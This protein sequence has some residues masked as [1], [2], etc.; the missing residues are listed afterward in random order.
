MAIIKID[1]P[2]M[3]SQIKQRGQT[4]YTGNKIS[5]IR[6]KSFPLQSSSG[7]RKLISSYLFNS[8]KRWL[9]L[10]DAN[11]ESWNNFSYSFPYFP[12]SQ[13]DQALMG[14][15]IFIKRN[16]HQQILNTSSLQFIDSP[17]PVS[18]DP[19]PPEVSIFIST[20]NL[21][22]SLIF[23]LSNSYFDCLISLSPPISPGISY[24]KFKSRIMIKPSNFTQTIDITQI[25]ISKFGRLPVPG[26]TIIFSIIEMGK[27][28]GIYPYE[29]N[30]KIIVT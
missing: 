29:D 28:D 18:L 10:S 17:A 2:D 24:V 16:T 20:G 21:Y 25:Y 27:Y 19:D 3:F 26:N 23:P 14:S 9:T 22:L 13:P 6:N 5:T 11:K 15:Q 8:V 1:R 30:Y 4:I 7:T 12:I